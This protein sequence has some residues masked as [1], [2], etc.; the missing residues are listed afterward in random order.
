MS[1]HH[2]HCHKSRS[3][4]PRRFDG[5]FFGLAPALFLPFLFTNNRRNVNIININTK[6]KSDDCDD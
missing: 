3:F 2:R 5:L 1:H 6:R 4:F